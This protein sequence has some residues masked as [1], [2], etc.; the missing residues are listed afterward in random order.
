[1]NMGGPEMAP[2]PPARLAA[3]AE[4]GRSPIHPVKLDERF[5]MKA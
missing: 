5:A 3:P 1:M 4:P 2:I